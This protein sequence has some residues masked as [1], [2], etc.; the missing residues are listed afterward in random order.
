V[1]ARALRDRKEKVFLTTEPHRAGQVWVAAT[2]F[3][4]LFSIVG[5]ALY[6]LPFYY[7]FMVKDFGWKTGQVTSGNAYS[8]LIVG[9]LFGFLAG[10]IVDRFGPRRLMIAGIV[11]AGAAL[12]GLSTISSL[13]TF[14]FFYL[15]NAMGY[16]CGG[17]LPN[18]V[19]LSRWFDRNRGKAMGFAYLGI[20]AGGAAVP[21]LSHWLT[22]ALGWHAALRTLGI[23]IIAV[24]LPMAFFVKDSPGREA[25]RASATGPASNP[26]VRSSAFR[27][28]VGSG[29]TPP[30]GTPLAAAPLAA[31]TTSTSEEA[32]L[33]EVLKSS[34][35]YLLAV[36][37]LCS[38]GAVGGTNQ[39]LKLYLSLDQNYP[40]GEI[41]R[42]LALVL[43]S[44]LA[45]RLLMGWLADRYPRKYVMLL[46]YGI[47]AVSIPV[48]AFAWTPQTVYLFAVL[49]G[50]GLGGDY[51]IVPLIAGDLF[52]VR[53]L[54]RVMGIIL[55]ADGMAEA[56]AP[57]IVA[58]IRDATNS[59]AAGFTLLIAIA[60][61]GA[62][63]AA[64]LPRTRKSPAG[65]PGPAIQS[66]AAAGNK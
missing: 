52:G 14:Y 23:A 37:S 60:A 20:G 26:A 1:R 59:Y 18:Q 65:E 46:I 19:L 42:I 22:D 8:K 25:P 45:G 40:Q 51:M 56:V 43:A 16:V 34:R 47:V 10:W 15:F 28:G 49:F 50:I 12:I 58:R 32:P 63:A 31:G 9:P 11:M 17:P 66:E 36:A 64:F 5:L 61:A 4:V 24:A 39:N 2:S 27:R 62:L 54:G 7:D 48:L 44:S 33:S 3:L 35:F 57:M 53:M 21:L 41:A 55:A 30:K 13:G 38:I 6:G 29:K